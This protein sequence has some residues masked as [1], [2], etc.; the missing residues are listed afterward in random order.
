MALI[1]R[2]SDVARAKAQGIVERA[3]ALKKEA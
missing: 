3:E 2:G 1:M